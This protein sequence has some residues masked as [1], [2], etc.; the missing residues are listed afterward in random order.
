M[1]RSPVVTS[2]VSWLTPLLLVMALFLLLRGHHEPGGGFAAGLVAAMVVLLEGQVRGAGQ[3]RRLLRGPPHRWIAIGLGLALIS[4]V[5][6]LVAGDPF[7]AAR[8]TTVAGVKLGTPLIFDLGVFALVTGV[9][10]TVALPLL[11]AAD[12]TAP[13]PDR[14][15]P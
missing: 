14:E 2:T 6:A 4:G 12:D 1:I 8:W 15:G 3:A 13:A 9:V 11:G 7:L 10:A 5:P